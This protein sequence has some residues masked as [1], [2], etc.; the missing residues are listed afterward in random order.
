MLQLDENERR[1]R[2]TREPR[3]PLVRILRAS[4]VLT[5]QRARTTM[6]SVMPQAGSNMFATFAVGRS[7]GSYV[8]TATYYESRCRLLLAR[9]WE[10]SELSE[11]HVIHGHGASHRR[12][13]RDNVGDVA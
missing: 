4:A 13:T 9:E 2:N 10:L 5:R 7:A 6:V 11:S 3:A 8:W 1:R 12:A